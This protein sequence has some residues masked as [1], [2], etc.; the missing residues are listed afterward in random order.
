MTLSSWS[1]GLEPRGYRLA[2]SLVGVNLDS[3]HAN[4]ETVGEAHSAVCGHRRRLD[5]WGYH[6]HAQ[7]RSCCRCSSVGNHIVI[8]GQERKVHPMR[9]L[10]IAFPI[11]K[12]G[13]LFFCRALNIE[14]KEWGDM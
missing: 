3:R 10:K 9:D 7:P 8:I 1:L 4:N 12:F 11:V 13:R 5:E 2:G 14:Q 6:V